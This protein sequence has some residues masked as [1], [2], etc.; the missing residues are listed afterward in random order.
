MTG[1][2]QVEVAQ[3]SMA[4]CL[5]LFALVA[6]PWKKEACSNFSIQLP[7]TFDN[8][9]LPCNQIMYDILYLTP[10]THYEMGEGLFNSWTL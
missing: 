1:L 7:P 8:V 4:S 9:N 10:V 5:Q 2:F 3:S 6:A